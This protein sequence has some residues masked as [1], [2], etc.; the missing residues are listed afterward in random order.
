MVQA[1]A[2]LLAGNLAEARRV[3]PAD[4]PEDP[5][6]MSLGARLLRACLTLS[7][8]ADAP[9][10]QLL[11]QVLADAERARLPWMV[12]MARAAQALSGSESG[13]AEARIVARECDRDGDE[14]GALFALGMRCLIRSID[15]D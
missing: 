4:L 2:H 1:A 7:G 8:G 6:F 3:L 14:W 11:A 12:R 9:G 13:A 10:Q 5:A 15:D